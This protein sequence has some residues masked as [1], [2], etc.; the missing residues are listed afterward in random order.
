MDVIVSNMRQQPWY[1]C[2]AH[3]CRCMVYINKI[4]DYFDKMNT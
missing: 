1:Q 2:S 4:N 3:Y